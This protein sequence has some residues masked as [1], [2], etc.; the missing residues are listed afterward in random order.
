MMLRKA[1][2]R[3]GVHVLDRARGSSLSTLPKV[4][5]SDRER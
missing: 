4:V 1:R 5:I 3:G 2:Q